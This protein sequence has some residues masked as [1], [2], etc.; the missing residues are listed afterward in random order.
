MKD[1]CVCTAGVGTLM[2]GLVVVGVGS[3]AA[4][5]VGGMGGEIMGD[6]IYESGK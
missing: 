2:F 6:V 5:A 4:G 3:F 1:P